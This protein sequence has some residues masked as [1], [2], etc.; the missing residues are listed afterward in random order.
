MGKIFEVNKETRCV[1]KQ[2]ECEA[3]DTYDK[4]DLFHIKVCLLCLCV[5]E[6]YEVC[7]VNT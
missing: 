3:Y 5:A 2:T 1:L 6:V 7:V 4:E